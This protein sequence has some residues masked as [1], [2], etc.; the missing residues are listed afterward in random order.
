MATMD[1][2]CAR[3]K[4]R[5]AWS[6]AQEATAVDRPGSAR[7]AV[8]ADAVRRRLPGPLVHAM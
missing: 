8:L 1:F 6:A 5:M 4:V 2:Q 7:V 3:R